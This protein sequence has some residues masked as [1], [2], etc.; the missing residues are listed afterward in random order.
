MAMP[1]P[2]LEKLQ[3]AMDAYHQGGQS[4]HEA[5]LLMGIPETTYHYWFRLAKEAGLK[6]SPSV[7]PTK[8]KEKKWDLEKRSL[9][10]TIRD[11]RAKL[12]AQERDS[13]RAARYSEFI[14]SVKTA[15][16]ETPKWALN[17]KGITGGP[18]IPIA[19]WSDWHVG[20]VVFPEQVGGLNEFNIAI[21]E[22]RVR[23]LVEKII[24]LCFHH[25]A[26][27]S[28]P[29]IV[30][31]LGGDLISGF[32]HDEL[33]ET[34]EG[35]RTQQ[36]LKTYELLAWALTALAEKFGKVWVVCVPG[37][38]GRMTMKIR[39]KNKVQDSYEYLIYK[40][41]ADR[42]KADKR[43]SFYISESTDAL[44]TVAGHRFLLTHG[45]STGAKGGDGFIGAIGPI[46]RGE[47][48]VR[49]ASSVVDDFY[50]T[51][52]MGHYHIYVSTDRVIV[53]PT[54]KGYD[55]YARNELRATP[56]VPAQNLLFV[57]GDH[58]IIDQ[59]R[60]FLE[61]RRPRSGALGVVEWRAA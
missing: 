13:I 2:S 40:I 39:A 43:L 16:P 5:A 20:E 53:N 18:G 23:T 6:P 42:F 54:L 8:E 58:G 33:I 11:L 12:A 26:H 31:C 37:N 49:D 25:T 48:K 7:N 61:K 27:P 22:R 51:C 10:D 52:L 44:F 56:E 55:E 4:K 14:Q 46:I 17:L 50:D 19:H 41:L 9:E 45:D 29:G 36:L 1:K 59:R 15:I 38:H 24:A 60:I 35:P 47:K 21:A 3:E 34:A 32:I 57:N 30:V 28:Y